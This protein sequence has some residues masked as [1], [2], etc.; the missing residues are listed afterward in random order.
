[1]AIK[2]PTYNFKGLTG[3]GAYARIEKVNGSKR[4][5][6]WQGL[7]RIYSGDAD[8]NPTPRKIGQ[9]TKLDER[10]TQILDADQ[11]LMLEDVYQAAAPQWIEE[12]SVC[13]PW[14][15]DAVPEKL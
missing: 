8:A 7:V 15:A 6:T 10:G 14:V 1:M 5:G 12:I 11:T 3:T 13:T 2:I 9:R 4:I